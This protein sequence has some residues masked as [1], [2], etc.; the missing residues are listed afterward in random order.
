MWR[1]LAAGSAALML[2]SEAAQAVDAQQRYNPHGLG[3]MTCKRFVEVCEKGDVN[4]KLSSTY[5]DGYITAFNAL[6]PE[7][8]DLLSWQDSGVV[9]EFAFNICKQ[10]PDA[11]L[12]E[13]LNEIVRRVLA[14]GRIRT[15][16]EPVRVGEG[17]DSVLLYRD[18]IREMQQRLVDTGHL[19]G[20]VDGSFGPGTKAAI[21]SFQTAVGLEPTGVPDPR[22]L[23]SL[24]YNTLRPGD[25]GG[26]AQGGAQQPRSPAPARTPSAPAA[27]TGNA[28]PGA[29]GPP[30]DLNLL[31]PR[32]P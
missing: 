13:A 30:L 3:R 1:I 26:P 20:G 12:I 17:K 29:G 25:G 16:A 22:T 8:F 14:P 19:K 28:A 10:H 2:W 21:T 23:A 9:A 15:A 31:A 5:I 32:S 24:F 27:G 4:C 7:T 6:N 18:S 11:V